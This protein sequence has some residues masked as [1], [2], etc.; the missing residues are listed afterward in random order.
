[1]LKVGQLIQIDRLVFI[2]F[3]QLFHLSLRGCW[4]P[5]CQKKREPKRNLQLS[6]RLLQ[7]S[8]AKQL[9]SSFQYFPTALQS[10]QRNLWCT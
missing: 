9:C 7:K 6:L 4:S 10:Q 5:L 3:W 1:M 2:V 8:V